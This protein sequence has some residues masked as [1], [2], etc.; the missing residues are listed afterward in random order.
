MLIY[1]IRTFLKDSRYYYISRYLDI[2]INLA[3][4]EV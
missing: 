4:N 1:L 2:K 3:I